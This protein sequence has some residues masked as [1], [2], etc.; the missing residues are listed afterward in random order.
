MRLLQLVPRIPPPADGVGATAVALARALG[1]EGLPSEIAVPAVEASRWQ[2]LAPDIVLLH[3]VNY[4]YDREGCPDWLVNEVE[5]WLRGDPARTL[6]VYFHEVYASGPPW[7][8]AFWQS[9]QQQRL[10]ARL[11][12]SSSL[13]LTSLSLYRDLIVGLGGRVEVVVR[14]IVSNVGE[15][16]DPTPFSGRAP[17]LV[18][19]GSATVRARAYGPFRNA[20]ENACA[21]LRIEEVLDIGNGDVAPTACG[22]RPVRARGELPPDQVS[23]LLS[24]ARAGFL[25]YPLDFL[26]KSSVFA[27]YAAHGVVPVCSGRRATRAEAPRAGVHYWDVG[28]CAEAPAD[29]DSLA[30]NAHA[31]YAAHDLRSLAMLLLRQAEAR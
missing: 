25:A 5:T 16:L 1:I 19:F 29:P 3:Y 31:W 7:R 26:G 24:T 2:K 28:R 27:A 10:A 15:P 21:A 18:V 17:I 11:A 9:R 13:S 30:A 23:Q 20:L 8:R 12:K 22:A 6:W 4:G 14:P